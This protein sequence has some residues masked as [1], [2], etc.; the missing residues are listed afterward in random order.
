[1]GLLKQAWRKIAPN[2][3]TAK[4]LRAQ[5][6]GVKKILIPWNRGLGDIA[7]GLYALVQMI[8]KALPHAEIHFWTRKDLAEGF[9][10]L[11][12]VFIH[13]DPAM[14]RGKEVEIPEH[15]RQE[16][17]WVID[18]PDPTYWCAWQLGTLTPALEL[19]VL[20]TAPS[21]FA[22]LE[23]IH[24]AI[25]V[26]V[27]SETVYG[28]EKNWPASHW[29]EVF[30]EIR[31]V[32][33]API[34]L[35]GFE[36]SVVYEDVIDLRGQTSLAALSSVIYHHCSHLV[37]PDSGILSLLYYYPWQKPLRAV[38]LWADPQQGILKQKVTSPNPYLKHTALIG[39]SLDIKKITPTALCEQL[40][41]RDEICQQL[42][43]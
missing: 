12:S 8:R 22:A 4:L 20:W 38:S 9:L 42:I 27:H 33:S 25:G 6:Q 11:G 31:K 3:F 23:G 1:M 16:F 37:L 10:L 14:R 13:V 24:N 2:P 5:R 17:D 15:I 18:N 21:N 43:F 34:V 28:Y 41:T 7:L 36:K 40:F 35:F 19:P 39:S 29:H 32:S 30:A 26:H